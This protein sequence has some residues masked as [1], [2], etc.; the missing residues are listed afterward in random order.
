MNIRD[1]L[2]APIIDTLPPVADIPPGVHEGNRSGMLTFNAIDVETANVDRASICQIGIVHVRNGAIRDQWH[3][4][5]NPEDWFDPWNVSIHGIDEDDV[6][7][8]PTLPEVRG[9]LGSRLRGSVLVSHTAFDRV[10][11]ERAMMRYSLEQLQVTWLDS[12]RIA[13]RAWPDRFG[14]SGYGLKSI[15]MDLNVSFKHHDAQ[16]DARAAAEIVLRACVATGTDIEGWRRRVDRPIFP[17]STVDASSAKRK[18]NV[19]GALYG[20]IVVFTGALGIPRRE[21]ADAAAEAGCDVANGVTKKTTMLVVGTQDKNKL[22]GYE[23]SSKHRKA[24]VLIKQGVDIQ[25]LSESDFSGLTGVA[26]PEGC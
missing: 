16:E 5:V 6:R 9:E 1:T 23:K 4:L 25:I 7:S 14:R 12:A 20:E 26:L 8:S 22:N 21:A 3:T 18:G 24:E 13:R 17:S 11:C 10:A 15:A 2:L 19:E